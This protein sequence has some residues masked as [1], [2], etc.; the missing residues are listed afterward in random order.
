METRVTAVTVNVADPLIVP[1]VAVIVADPG[2][3][4]VA[5]PLPLM[6]AMEVAEDVQV[7]VPVRF[8]V[9]PLLYVPVAVNCCVFPT[10]REGAAGVTAMEVNTAAE[11]VRVAVPLILE[12]VAVTVTVPG[13]TPFANPV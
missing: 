9:V 13:A 2:A 7:A 3:M 11:T 5:K 12:E 8:L 4:V 10:A 6:V 1:E